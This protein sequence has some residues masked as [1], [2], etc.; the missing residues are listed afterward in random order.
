MNLYLVRAITEKTGNLD[1]RAT[2]HPEVR[3]Y[4]L[5]VQ[6]NLALRVHTLK[7]QPYGFALFGTGPAEIFKQ[8]LVLPLPLH[9]L[10]EPEL[11]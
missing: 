2:E 3:T 5:F 8:P 11:L 9:R 4:Q 7:H 1:A 6:V 10:D